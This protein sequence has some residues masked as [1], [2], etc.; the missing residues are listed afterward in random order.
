MYVGGILE[1]WIYIIDSFWVKIDSSVDI[2]FVKE[3]RDICNKQ[4]SFYRRGDVYRV[5][6]VHRSYGVFNFHSHF[7][8]GNLGVDNDWYFLYVYLILRH[9]VF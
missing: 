6:L 1:H 9:N 8:L 2:D 4:I 5:V 3:S 7:L